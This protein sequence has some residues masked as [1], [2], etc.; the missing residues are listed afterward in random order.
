MKVLCEFHT[1]M[2]MIYIDTASC[3]LDNEGRRNDSNIDFE[4][5][6]PYVGKLECTWTGCQING[7]QLSYDWKEIE[8][9]SDFC[10]ALE[11]SNLPK[12]GFYRLNNRYVFCE[13]GNG[14]H[15]NK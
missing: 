12:S 13:F 7:L 9:I 14:R 3:T 6:T 5:L 11:N 1:I 2:L 4:T 15:D 8:K 10:I